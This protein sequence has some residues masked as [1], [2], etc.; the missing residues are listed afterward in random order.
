M[1][2]PIVP[3][4]AAP[5]LRRPLLGYG[6]V[7]V[8]AVLFAINGSVSKV[9][10]RSGLAADRLTEIRCTGA[11]VG[12]A[13]V[14]AL[15][16]RS[17]LRLT[18]RELG[19]LAMFGIGGVALVQWTYFV[20]IDRLQV[21][22]ALLIQF[23]GPLLVAL[24]A[25]LVYHENVRRR[26]WLS[27]ALS[28]TGLVL[29]VRIWTGLALDGI[30]LLAGL[31]AMVAYAGYVLMAERGVRRRSSVAL[32]AWG[33]LF[34]T[35]FWS[36][37]LPWWSFPA[38]TVGSTASLLGRFADVHVPVA[39]LVG[40]VIVPG[41]LAPFALIVAALRHVSATRVGIVG[42]LEPVTAT[43]VAWLWLGE[44]LAAVQLVGAAVV[45]VAIAIAQTAR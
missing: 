28:L 3:P 23:V 38:D 45:L 42:M 21:G 10:I 19:F 4:D 26:I 39:L 25:R 9:V 12:F 6:M 27:L 15:S 24:W 13:L 36:I 1:A 41:T 31:G 43:L 34:A 30:G 11:L 22:V 16:R 32:L 7:C 17:E 33:F 44:S 14:A 2:E 29:V 8:A 5:D 35:L 18:L 40:W 37:V 20:A